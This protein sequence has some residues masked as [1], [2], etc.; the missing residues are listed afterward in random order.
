MA[1]GDAYSV[2][3]VPFLPRTKNRSASHVHNLFPSH[4]TPAILRRIPTPP[5]PAVIRRYRRKFLLIPCMLQAFCISLLIGLFFRPNH[6]HHVI[7]DKR[8]NPVSAP[9]RSQGE[10]PFPPDTFNPFQIPPGPTGRYSPL[11]HSPCV[12]ARCF[13]PSDK[14]ASRG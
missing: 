2:S 9:P 13:F 3:T 10:A 8:L 14:P 7:G 12:L 6:A 5:I 11:N 1:L 4:P